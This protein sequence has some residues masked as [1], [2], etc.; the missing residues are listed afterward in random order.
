MT[1]NTTTGPA[2]NL[3]EELILMLLNEQTGYFHQV[4][5]WDLNCAVAGAVLAELSL[6]SRIDTDLETLT[7]LDGT[8]TGDAAIDPIL[9][10]IAAEPESHDAQ[11]WVE[12]LAA[13]A[14]GIIDR[15]LDRLVEMGIIEHHAGDF[16]TL[17]GAFHEGAAQE[18]IKTRVTK[19]LFTDEI[20]D[21]RDI[22]VISL[23]DTC[24]VFRFIF[25]LDEAT[26]ERIAEICRMDLI[27]RSIAAA[28][29][30]NIASPLLR[31]PTLTKKIPAVSLRDL[32]FNRELREG[33]LP[34]GFAALAEKYGPVFEIRLPFRKNII[35]LAGVKTNEWAHRMGRVFLRSKEYFEGVDKAYGVSRSVH[36]TDGADHFRFRKSLHT[37]YSRKTLTRRLDDVY[38]LA[39]THMA[40]WEVGAEM[41]AQEML[42]PF[43]NAQSSP[44]LANID[45]QDE[46]IDALEYKVRVLNVGI[47]KTMPRFMLNTPSMRRR[48]KVTQRIIDRMQRTHSAGQQAGKHQ[49]VVDAYLAL[50][51]SDPQF[52]PETDLPLPLGA[53]LMTAMYMGDQTGFALYWLMQ[54]PEL[55]ARVTA[56]AD[57]LWADGD[58]T[59]ENFTRERIDV[60]HR[61]LMETLRMSPI[62]PMSM[63]TVTNS[64]VVEGYELPVGSQLMIAQ[65]AA[66]YS[67]EAFPDPW[68]FDID[69][70]APPRNEHLGRG[71]APYGLG[72]HSCLGTHWADL[73]ITINL[74][75]LTHYFK[76]ELA[77]PFER[78]PMDALPSQ[79]P[80]NKIKFRLAE[81]RHELPPAP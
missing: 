51:S 27:A 35:V 77:R 59:E 21:P 1:D 61:V 80:S 71:Y 18:F 23:V 10:E 5:G 67:E 63:R 52:L 39:R 34:A 7:L 69:R 56:E 41:P 44:L 19:A 50:H 79:S 73:H 11:F 29:E 9:E 14:E 8:P 48:A 55:Y 13:Q 3:P 47:V 46:I 31:R 26:E 70:Y 40:N 49:D 74:L 38:D 72:T 12:R 25:E 58:P 81:R 45:T 43:L 32:V 54:D 53:I 17:S 42:R 16:W 64:C 4:A 75:M 66:H 20:P 30:H 76:I 36:S 6:R 68:T 2:L 22:L 28:V 37:A 57:A 33:R 65:T 15:T 78:M 62:V 60:T 24:G